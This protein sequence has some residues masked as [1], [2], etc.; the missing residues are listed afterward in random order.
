MNYIYAECSLEDDDYLASNSEFSKL[1]PFLISMEESTKSLK[2][3]KI[4]CVKISLIRI[5]LNS[6]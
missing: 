5:S 3:C 1:T 4:R 2:L 6:L